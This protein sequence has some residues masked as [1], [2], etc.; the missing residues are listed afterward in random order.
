MR[1]YRKYLAYNQSLIS[2]FSR[3]LDALRQYMSVDQTEEERKIA[4]AKKHFRLGT[5]ADVLLLTPN[6]FEKQFVVTEAS[7]KL[8]GQ[9]ATLFRE[10][11]AAGR[12]DFDLDLLE[13]LS[14][15]VKFT[16]DKGNSRIGLYA[17][18]KD[19]A[20]RKA[21]IA[22]SQELFE[23]ML[24]SGDKIQIS[25]AELDTVLD[26]V[27]S[28]KSTSGIGEYFNIGRNGDIE[29]L[30]QVA[31]YAK[32]D[33]EVQG[34][35]PEIKGLLDL[36]ILYHN[37]KVIKPKDLKTKG[38]SATN[39]PKAWLDLYKYQDAMYSFLVRKW[40][41]ENY[42]DYTIE[43]F[44]FIVKSFK[45]PSERVMVFQASEQARLAATVGGKING[46][47]VAGFL[48]L[49][50]KLV[51]QDLTGQYQLTP[52]NLERL[53]AGKPIIVDEDWR[54]E[55]SADDSHLP[56]PADDFAYLNTDEISF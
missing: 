2:A 6:D 20:K 37:R 3:G 5:A 18:T 51:E 4:K 56:D 45:Y 14:T 55:I 32:L 7:Y 44:E 38:D 22:E 15:E 25:T 26:A 8:D 35:V 34:I 33:F 9:D 31:I 49:C 17:S 19:K 36:L 16:D 11:I 50:E 53:N 52:K 40:R 43:P 12:R 10:Y 30:T 54:V 21:K 39:F 28:I 41:D 27:R 13:Q 1:D 46:R 42:P 24:N 29:V 48:S 47:P 23:Y